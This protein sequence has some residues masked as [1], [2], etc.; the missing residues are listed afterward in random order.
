MTADA[1]LTHLC[2][3]TDYLLL[4]LNILGWHMRD[5]LHPSAIARGVNDAS[6][7]LVRAQFW[8]FGQGQHQ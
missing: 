6:D 1:S 2:L 3:S 5:N 4:S 8:L 7:R